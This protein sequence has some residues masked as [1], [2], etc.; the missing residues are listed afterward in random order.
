MRKNKSYEIR[1]VFS[2]D[3][4]SALSCFWVTYCSNYAGSK[5]GFHEIQDMAGGK[6]CQD[7]LR[8]S[9]LTNGLRA[10]QEFIDSFRNSFRRLT[11]NTDTQGEQTSLTDVVLLIHPGQDR[12]E[13][14]QRMGLRLVPS[15]S[16]S[17]EQRGTGGRLDLR[18]TAPLLPF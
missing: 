10:F 5:P 2:E 7:Y 15:P 16:S 4:I 1:Q 14:Q 11:T 3:F 12:A 13:K 18:F 9:V 17:R 6:T 8:S